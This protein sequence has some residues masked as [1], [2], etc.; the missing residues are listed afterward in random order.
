MRPVLGP[1]CAFVA[2]LIPSTA[3]AEG[4]CEDVAISGTPRLSIADAY[5]PFA[6][7]D[8]TA[9]TTVTIQNAGDDA[10]PLD[11]VFAAADNGQLRNAG[12]TLSYTLETSDGAALLNRPGIADPEAGHH[13]DLPLPGGQAASL[14]VRARVPAQQMA[15]PGGYADDTAVIRLYHM[16]ADG[17]PTLLTERPFPVSAEVAAVCRLSPPQ[18]PTL[19]FTSDIGPDARP[20]GR[21]RSAQMPEAACNTGA[22]LKLSGAALARDGE[23]PAGFD[24]VIDFKA[25]A[26]FRS[27]AATLVTRGGEEVAAQSARAGTNGTAEPVKLDVQ[28]R[29]GRPLAAGRYQSVL[30]IALEPSP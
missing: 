24:D 6:A 22:R 3:I 27:V 10:C 16:P 25:R 8:L 21:P 23:V 20:Q 19:D 29:P 13:I 26:R 7:T 14:S 1:L 12:E 11:V 30:T 28:L 4:A 5:S 18:P 2:V 15:P 9:L 17:F